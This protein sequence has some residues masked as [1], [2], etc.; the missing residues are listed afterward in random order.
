LSHGCWQQLDDVYADLAL[1]T[2]DLPKKKLH[3]HHE[4]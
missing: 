1:K 3:R 4:K 2:L